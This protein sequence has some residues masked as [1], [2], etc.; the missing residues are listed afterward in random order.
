MTRLRGRPIERLDDPEADAHWVTDEDGQIT[1][2]IFCCPIHEDCSGYIGPTFGPWQ[3]SGSS[4]ST[5]TVWP[6]IRVGASD[7]E[8]ECHWHGFIRNGRFEHCG[9]AR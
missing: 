2:L 9:D 6:S 3:R 4:L 7:P 1:G 5:V 8:G